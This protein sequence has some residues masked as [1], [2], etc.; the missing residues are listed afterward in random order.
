[1]FDGM[2]LAVRQY[3]LPKD[4]RHPEPPIPPNRV[5]LVAIKIRYLI[6]ELIPVEVKVTVDKESGFDWQETSV[7]RPNSRIITE[8]VL[9]LVWE[10]G[11]DDKACIIFALM[12]CRK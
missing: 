5:S 10:A 6:Q 1:M 3:L 2:S 12:A 4:N 8:Q 11:G 7:T 9:K